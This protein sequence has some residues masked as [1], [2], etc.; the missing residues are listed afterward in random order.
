MVG[1]PVGPLFAVATDE[2]V[3]PRLRVDPHHWADAVR[4]HG[5]VLQL[6]PAL[7]Q[8]DGTRL[9]PRPTSRSRRSPRASLDELTAA[10]V[11]GADAVRGVPHVDVA[12]LLAALPPLDLA[13][14]DADTAWAVLVGFGIGGAEASLPDAQA[15]LVALIEALPPPVAERLLVELLGRLVEPRG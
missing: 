9:P 12:P 4:G 5:F 2:T 3:R 1:D 6:Q 10:L 11:A 13:A 15:P 8:G 14:L 7:R